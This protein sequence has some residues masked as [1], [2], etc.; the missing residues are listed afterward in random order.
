MESR[1]AFKV[2]DNDAGVAFAASGAFFTTEMILS[3]FTI[4]WGVGLLIGILA[5][6]SYIWANYLTDDDFE[7]YFNNSW[8]RK[9]DGDKYEIFYKRI[10]GRILAVCQPYL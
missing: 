1:D 9:L 3:F 4:P 2:G 6:G 7:N 10:G 8:F 5:I